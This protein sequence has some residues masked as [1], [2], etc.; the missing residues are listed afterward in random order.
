MTNLLPIIVAVILLVAGLVVLR[1]MGAWLRT[2]QRLA[3]AAEASQAA[4]EAILVTRDSWLGRWLFRA[5]FRGKNA[6]PLF[7]AAN[8]FALLAGLLVAFLFY[9]S[10]VVTLGGSVLRAIPGA[11]GEVFLPLLWVSPIL[12]VGVVVAMPAIFVR[13]RRRTRIRTIEQDLP[14]SLDLLATLAEAGLSFDAALERVLET[15]RNRRPL[16]E[17]FRLFRLEILTGRSRIDS[18]RRLKDNVDVTWFSIFVSALIHAEQIGASLATT[19]RAQADDLRN[20]RRERALA[21][22]MA[23][24]VKLLFPLIICFLPGI[25]IAA[26]GPIIFQIVQMLDQVIQNG[27]GGA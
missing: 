15:Q 26:L 1:Y 9:Q 25:M 4:D 13:A 16:A 3:A 18:L 24:P 22:A 8:V 27:F 17:E 2:R 20:R 19:L 5:G 10:A 21:Q 7:I 11:V 23:V 6:T 12:A 14:L